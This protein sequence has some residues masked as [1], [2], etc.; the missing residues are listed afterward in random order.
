M[1]ALKIKNTQ[2]PD[3]FHLKILVTAIITIQETN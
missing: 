1:L 2:F 3:G